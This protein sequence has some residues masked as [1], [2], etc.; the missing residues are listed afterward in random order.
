MSAS[1]VFTAI[2]AYT[3]LLF[4]VAR[5]GDQTRFSEDSWSRHPYVYALALGVYCTSWTFYGL[6]GTA[7]TSTWDFLPILLG[8]ILLFT[9]GWPI[10]NKIFLICRQEHIHSIADFLASRY[11]KRQGIAA[12]TTLV[13]LL[14]TVPY[15]S[16][17]LKAVSDTLS[18]IID[19]HQVGNQD[20]TLLIA[21]SMI[22][23]ALLFGSRQ[24]DVSGYHAGLVSAVAFESLIK[25]VA[26]FFVTGFALYWMSGVS[27]E[28]IELSK[29]D[30]NTIAV[31]DSIDLRFFVEMFLSAC[32]IF[33]LPRMFHIAFVECQS[34]NHLRTARYVFPIYLTLIGLCIYFIAQAGNLMFADGQVSA[35]TYVISIPLAQEQQTL[36]LIAF[37]GGFSAATAMI[38]VATVT[39]SQMLSNDVILPII[40]RRQKGANRFKDYTQS[41]IFARRLT[42]VLVVIFAYL[43]QVV[44]AEN[45]ALTS[46]GLTAFALAV[47]LAPAIIFGLYWTRSN[48]TGIYAGLA[49]GLITWAYTLMLPLLVDTGM[50]SKDLLSQGP[51]GVKWLRPE[52]LFG[53]SFSDEF[54]RGVVLSLLANIL[55][56]IVVSR[57]NRTTLSDRIQALA[58]TNQSQ[59]R[60]SEYQNY[61]DISTFDLRSLL[62]QFVGSSITNKLFG[63]YDHTSGNTADARLI[64]KAQQ[65]LSGIVGVASSQAMIESLRSGQKLA[66]EEVVNIF[67]ETTRALRFNQDILFASF[68]NISSGISVVNGDLNMIAWNRRYEEMFNYPQG[69]LQIGIAVSDLVRFNAERGLLGPGA[70]DEHVQRRLKHLMQGKPYRVVRKH[71]NGHVIEI[72]GNPLPDGG[73]VTT[74]DDI[75]D[76]M[77]AQDELEQNNLYLEQRV[78]SRTAQIES[79]NQDL[80]KEIELRKEVEEQLLKAKAVAE[81]A[82]TTK[83]RFLALASHD[84]LQPIN[85]A[86]LYANTLLD[87]KEDRRDMSTIVQIRDA[88]LSAESIISS[89]LEIA[90]LDTGT[91]SPQLSRFKLDDILQPLVNEFKVLVK[92]EVELHFVPS[93]LVVESDKK[94]LRRILQNFFS[95]AVKY[96]ESGKILVGCRREG[97]RVRV[98]VYDTGSGI[99]E[100]DQARIFSDFYRAPTQKSIAGLG[101]GLAVAERLAELLQ[102]PISLDSKLRKGSCFSISLPQSHLPKIIEAP[103]EIANE[104]DIEGLNVIYVDDQQENL[105]ATEALLNKWNCKMLSYNSAESILDDSTKHFVPDV[106]LMDYQLTHDEGEDKYSNGIKLAN[107]LLEIWGQ[108]VPVCIISAASE[109]ELA[110]IAKGQGFNFLSKPLKPAKLRALLSQLVRRKKQS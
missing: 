97:E 22:G 70:I 93:S 41:L 110:S 79:I 105:K 72:K 1:I 84:I 46:I 98:C 26:L 100:T 71:H 81:E 9:L 80:R 48:A 28:Q 99:A 101:L 25:L 109:P 57:Q 108:D 47:Q 95:N 21:F 15:I 67:E 31:S 5:Q 86:Q 29:Q 40:M 10:L 96:T 33:C 14:A 51:L 60:A 4:W 11:G 39:L 63:E 89:L 24:L 62:E 107:E 30:L 87:V 94:Y 52:F 49:A 37:L 73:Y 56:T 32:A 59:K 78:Q 20:V 104:S 17:Q 44:F 85:A 68:D 77:A 6:V 65:S 91:L 92:D 38:I 12:T 102:H 34:E 69:M 83:S 106:L 64:K 8:P 61:D 43:Y 18:L 54:S 88:I 74:Y 19:T 27:P 23:F 103:Q 82:N 13:I 76:F 7:S 3:A 90:R 45:A 66:V 42:V 36:S 58:F 35:D 2:I 55:T 50:V 75:T 16:L 53:L